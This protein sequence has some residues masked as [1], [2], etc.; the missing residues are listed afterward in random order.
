MFA[1]NA[2]TTVVSPSVATSLSHRVFCGDFAIRSVAVCW[3]T[4]AR[5]YL[6]LKA[7]HDRK[8]IQLKN[9]KWTRVGMSAEDYAALCA[10]D[11]EL[12]ELRSMAPSIIIELPE[13]DRQERLVEMRSLKK[14]ISDMTDRCVTLFCFHP[15]VVFYSAVQPHM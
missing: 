12:D 1:N 3:H 4:R 10:L 15:Q 5:R 9:L 8:A 11:E 14:Q 7:T 13:E 2:R 6:Q